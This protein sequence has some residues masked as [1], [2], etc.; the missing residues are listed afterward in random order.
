LIGDVR[1]WSL[2]Q[3]GGQPCV[4]GAYHSYVARKLVGLADGSM[5]GVNTN[6]KD[7]AAV[8]LTVQ[9]ARGRLRLQRRCASSVIR[10]RDE[11]LGAGGY[12]SR[13]MARAE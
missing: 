7:M 2:I 1:S 5:K 13:L 10:Q 8:G 9:E 6:A 4:R 11:L 12:D 3:R